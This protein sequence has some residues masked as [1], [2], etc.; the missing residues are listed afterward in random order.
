MIMILMMIIFIFIII[1]NDAD[2]EGVRK[3]IKSTEKKDLQNPTNI[4]LC[5]LQQ[6]FAGTISMALRR[7]SLDCLRI[8]MAMP[9]LLFLPLG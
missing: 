3:M 4:F 2:V 1:F 8:E 5:L 6:R 9:V 7:S